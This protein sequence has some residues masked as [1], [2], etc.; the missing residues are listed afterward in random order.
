MFLFILNSQKAGSYGRVSFEPSKNNFNQ[1]IHKF[2]N[3][4][5]TQK[6]NQNK[7]VSKKSDS[8]GGRRIT[9]DTMNG[10][11][12]FVSRPE[13][14]RELAKNLWKMKKSNHYILETTIKHLLNTFPELMDL[15]K[16]NEDCKKSNLNQ[17]NK[18]A[19]IKEDS[20]Q[21]KRMNDIS[22]KKGNIYPQKD[23]T[24]WQ[25]EMP[26]RSKRK[27][28]E[29]CL[30]QE[31]RKRCLKERRDSFSST[32]ST[33]SKPSIQ[34]E[35]R[36]SGNQGKEYDYVNNIEPYDLTLEEDQDSIDQLEADLMDESLIE[37]TNIVNE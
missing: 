33:S 29:K 10:K 34:S 36:N 24:N 22:D 14:T 30:P 15:I 26:K 20:V 17:H 6:T 19:S 27:K 32:S 2:I 23:T 11:L 16:E 8:R 4:N 9:Y 7:D 12:K 21:M 37:L 28:L 18:I 35:P 5:L 25:I 13:R 1:E 3:N 31:K